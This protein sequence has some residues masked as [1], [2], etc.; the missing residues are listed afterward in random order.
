M[1]A[2]SHMSDTQA[3]ESKTEHKLRRR[4]SLLLK[5]A[6]A[7]RGAPF[8][9]W[10]GL[11]VIISYGL[12]GLFAPL[13]APYQESQIVSAIAYA[14][15]SAQNWLGGDQLGRDMLTRIIFGARNSVS[16]ALMTALLAFALGAGCGILSAIFKGFFDLLLSRVFDILMSVPQL[17]FALILLSIFGSS[18]LNLVAIIAVLDSTRVYR[19][20]RSAAMNIA[21]MDFVEVARLRGE[22]FSWIMGREIL[23]NI[24]PTL[25]AEFGIRFNFIFLTTSSLSFLGL[26]IQPPT[27]DWGSMVRENAALITYGDITPLLPAAAISLLTLA[28]NFVVDWLVQK[29]HA[30]RDE[31]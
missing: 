18:T 9:V 16:I 27:A 19:V 11:A 10:L 1:T 23:P 20:S 24:L 21:A 6:R 29:S 14:P 5:A 31:T 13:L 7:L 4:R 28:V 8:T 15:W 30:A 22:R 25:L 3:A 26:G 2:A 17:I 12:L